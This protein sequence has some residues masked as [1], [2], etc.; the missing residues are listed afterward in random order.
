MMPRFSRPCQGRC[1]PGTRLFAAALA[2]GLALAGRGLAQAPAPC[3]TINGFPPTAP[4][5]PQSAPKPAEGPGSVP[6]FV[7]GVS[8][9]DAGFEVV[10]GQGRILT[11]KEDIAARG[12]PS[13]L[14]ALGDPTVADFAIVGPR[15]IRIIGERLG[16]TDLS[17]TTSDGRTFT[18]EIRVV[19]DLDVLR[20][21]LRCIFPDA[22]LKLAQFRDHIVVEGQARSPQQV[23]RIMETIQAYLAS[24]TSQQLRKIIGQGV[25]PPEV[26]PP[27]GVRPDGLPPA[28]GPELR[29]QLSVT[30]QIAP[31][32]VINLIRVP[33]SQQVLLKV[34]VAELDRT[35]SRAIGADLLSFFTST[36]AAFGTNLGN[37]TTVAAGELLGHTFTTTAAAANVPGTTT[38]FGIFPRDNFE[39]MV[40][41]L[42]RNNLL[43][44]LAE[45]N[46]VAL[47]GQRAS[48]LA[49]GQF[50]IPTSQ[51]SVGSVSGGVTAQPVNFG[52]SLDFQAFI[53]DDDV[54]RLTVDPEVSQPDFT[55]AVTLVPGGSP[56][57]GLNKRGA[58]TTVEM[59]QGQTLAI[60]GLMSL[61]LDGSTFRIPGLGDLPI[62]GPFFSNTTGSR[63]EKELVVLVTPYLVEPMNADQVPPSPGDE[64]KEP[65]D[66]EFYLLNRIEGRTG[67]DFRSTVQYDDALGVLRCLLRLHDQ[68]VRGPQGYCD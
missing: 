57:P 60:A 47:S 42:R 68:H 31:P 3:A 52:V 28:A 44:V 32:R 12:K 7:D 49:G 1:R 21:Q 64:V 16:T 6:S 4:P 59:R 61:T 46:L 9:T 25:A 33:T 11:T 39:A 20:T 35:A 36:G 27:G 24:V 17:I 53:L 40:Q 54:I 63:T 43:K 66:L 62:L 50:F 18:F 10:L 15:Q 48:F 37:G 56:V 45:P 5:T 13:A 2:C 38:T 41:A 34:R 55:V 8:V 30:A 58:H 23:A 67:V 14:V 26:M 19:A 65:T 29:P 22:S 51:T